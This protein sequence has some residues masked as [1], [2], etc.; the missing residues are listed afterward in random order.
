MPPALRV[1]SH[2]TGQVLRNPK[3]VGWSSEA[4]PPQSLR[5]TRRSSAF[6]KLLH[7]LFDFRQGLRR[8]DA[9][10]IVRGDDHEDGEAVLEGAK[11]FQPLT[12]SSAPGESEVKCW[13]KEFRKA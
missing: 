9:D 10:G 13:R 11:L 3:T 4:D 2:S 1:E 12:C 6:G 7:D 8:I 5:P